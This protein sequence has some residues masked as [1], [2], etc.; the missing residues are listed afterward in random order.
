[1]P[2][3]PEDGW[4]LFDDAVGRVL[5]VATHPDDLEYGPAAA[6]ARWTA[7]G[8]EVTYLLVTRGEAGIDGLEP[9]E[10]AAVRTEEQERSAAVVGVDVVEFLDHADGVLQYGLSLRRDIAAAIRRHQPDTVVTINHRE[11]W[12]GASALNSADHRAVGWSVL[13]AV[14]DA[15]NRWIFPAV[16]EPHQAQRVLIAGSPQARVGIDVSGTVDVAVASLAEHRAYLEGL[17]DHPMS[18]PEFLRMVLGGV[19]A[20]VGCVAAVGVEVFRF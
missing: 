9:E 19:G 20:K 16:G 18:D 14:A 7:T 10:C 1:M 17:G 12:D 4:E 13:D 8:H 11:T 6:V 5:A 3:M 15:G 2:L